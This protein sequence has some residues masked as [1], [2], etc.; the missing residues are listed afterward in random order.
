MRRTPA[1]LDAVTRTR[2]DARTDAQGCC[3]VPGNHHF[4]EFKPTRRFIC[5]SRAFALVLF[6]STTC[7][8][9]DRQESLR[10]A[11]LKVVTVLKGIS[12]LMYSCMSRWRSDPAPPA[13]TYAFP[14]RSARP[15]DPAP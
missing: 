14:S 12:A 9:V 13:L 8:K 2:T 3:E 1:S 5:S 10:S 6:A 7:S 4:S 15:T 11:G